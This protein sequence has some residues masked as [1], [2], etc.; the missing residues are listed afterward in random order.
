[1]KKLLLLLLMAISSSTFAM[2]RKA[3]FQ[4][5]SQEAPKAQ[6][7][8][9]AGMPEMWVYEKLL[10]EGISKEQILAEIELAYPADES[11]SKPQA[12]VFFKN[13]LYIHFED[14]KDNII[15]KFNG[16][17]WFSADRLRRP[18]IGHPN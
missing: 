10:E 11:E 13:G 17:P 9:P 7:K 3:D 14:S 15:R 2:Q 12:H 5:A 8:W 6:D 18:L 4:K 16:K 1:M